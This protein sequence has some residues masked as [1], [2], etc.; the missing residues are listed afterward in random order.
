MLLKDPKAPTTLVFILS[1]I[2]MFSASMVLLMYFD[3]FSHNVFKYT[4]YFGD[5]DTP[6]YSLAVAL[7]L[8]I[9]LTSVVTLFRNKPL[10]YIW[11][12]KAFVTLIVMIPYEMYYGLDAYLYFAEA[13]H[14]TGEHT[15]GKTGTFNTTFVNYLFTFIGG[16]SYYSLK[17]INSFIAFLGLVL[18]YKSYELIVKRSGLSIE[19]DN[20]I[21]I[22][23]LFPSILFWSSILGKDP[24]NLLSVGIFTYGFVHF[25]NKKRI[26]SLLLVITAIIGIHF[27]RSW[28]SIIMIISISLFFVRLTS[29]KRNIVLLPLFP[30]LYFA[31]SYFLTMQGIS[32]FQDIFYKMSYTSYVLA[33][34]GSSLEYTH[35]N[36]IWDYLL[37]Y[38]PNL[39]TSL[40]RPMPWDIR[41]PFSLLAAI[42][43][44]LLLYF[45]YKYIIKNWRDVLKNK[46]LRFLMLFIFSWSLFY[47]IISPTNL[48]MAVRFKLQV[49]PAMLIVIWVSR[50]IYLQKQKQKRDMIE[51]ERKRLSIGQRAKRDLDIEKQ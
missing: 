30:F 25:I 15:H 41:N 21:Y 13:V 14:F 1:V 39:F 37:F 45:T 43:N 38:I 23:F 50:H 11:L 7:L 6:Y 5:Y 31:F 10:T 24:L 33:Y 17:L 47:V 18:I 32:S 51:V 40:F 34:G 8:F 46:Y 42:E 3:L 16:E 19:N 29:I 35:I 49:L 48:G 4:R 27:I 26:Y 36:N 12:I 20:F 28:Y 22:F 44:V 9:G 2:V